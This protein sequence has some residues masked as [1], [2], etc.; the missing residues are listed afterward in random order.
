MNES[1][2]SDVA[3]IYKSESGRVL[4]SLVRILGDLDLAEEALQEAII[5]A[6]NK[7]PREGIPENQY[8]WL[9]STGKFKA[10]GSIRRSSRGRELTFENW[11]V[12]N[13]TRPQEFHKNRVED[14]HLRS[15]YYCCYPVLPLGSRIDLSLKEVCG[16]RTEEITRAYL[17]PSYS[18]VPV[19]YFY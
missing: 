8:S 14:D 18:K 10:I 13:N 5:E 6:L 16:M 1:I 7:W 15:I 3:Q 17:I 12:D 19:F 4:A 2:K 9:V 11:F